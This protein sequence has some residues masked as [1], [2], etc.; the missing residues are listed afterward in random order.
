MRRVGGLADLHVEWRRVPRF[1]RHLQRVKRRMQ[2]L[3]LSGA[4]EIN[5]LAILAVE[6]F[7][8]PRIARALEYVTW[9][10]LSALSSTRVATLTV[11]MSQ[12]QLCYWEEL[13]L[14]D[15]HRFSPERLAGVARA[16]QPGW[17]PRGPSRRRHGE[18]VGHS[19][20]RHTCAQ[21]CGS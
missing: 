7:Y 11:G 18:D 9:A 10:L 1:E 4:G 13:G 14:I 21:S 6:S 3:A 12:A 19:G 20:L 15:G 16:G 5:V 17:R 2:G 8:R